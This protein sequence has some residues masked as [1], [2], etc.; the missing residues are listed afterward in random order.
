MR[1]ILKIDGGLQNRFQMYQKYISKIKLESKEELLVS[2]E[3]VA[4]GEVLLEIEIPTLRNLILGYS[5]KSAGNFNPNH[6][7]KE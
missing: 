6:I 2:L 4:T 5:Y 1:T 7:K 3:K